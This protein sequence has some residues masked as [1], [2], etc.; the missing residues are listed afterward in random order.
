MQPS[1]TT[2]RKSSRTGFLFSIAITLGLS[3]FIL[4]QRQWIVDNVHYYSYQ[5]TPSIQMI[6]TNTTM[7]DDGKFYFYASRPQLA[8][9]TVFNDECQRREADSPVLGCYMYQRIFVYDITNQKLNGIEEVTAAH[10]MLHAVWDRMSDDEKATISAELNENYNRLKNKDL[11][12]RMA[13]YEK[14]E[15]GEE[16]NEL[17]A[18]LG[19]EFRNLSDDLEEHYKRYFTDRSAVVDYHDAS[20][21]IFEQLSNRSKEIAAELT[22]L[23]DTINAQ[24]KRYNAEAASLSQTIAEFN[25]RADRQ[26]GFIS[27]AE[28]NA[29]RAVLVAQT[30]SLRGQ[31]TQIMNDITRY[32]A[33]R[34]ELEA[35]AA[36]SEALN[37]SIDSTLVP[38]TGL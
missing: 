7:T 22:Q 14:H 12:E 5:P 32:E 16:S 18:I 29:E 20:H 31:R 4:S 17:F 2:A 13:Y 8:T 26:N 28:F 9:R 24:T 25:A 11:I 30:E 6:A 1:K 3:L 35:V 23:V 38:A 19:T 33:L 15:P 34:D 27:E 10:E 21:G 36:E 37:R